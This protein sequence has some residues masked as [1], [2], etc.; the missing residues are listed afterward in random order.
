MALAARLKKM[1]QPKYQ[2][3]GKPPLSGPGFG[4]T[5]HPAVLLWPL[6]KKTPIRIFITSMGDLFHDE[7]PADFIAQCFA[8]MAL[9]GRHTFQ[10]LS[11]RHGR[12]RSLLRRG[13]FRDAVARHATAIITS[14][15]WQ[16]WQL[17][18]GGQRL[19]G[20][21]GSGGGWT[22]IKT[23]RGNVWHP[24]WPLPNVHMGVSAEDQHWFDIR[25]PA[26]RETPAAVRW[27]SAE[28]LLGPIDFGE[29]TYLDWVV[30][31]GESGPGHRPM[32]IGWLADV[33][34]QCR[35][36]G[37]PYFVKQDSGPKPGCQG[38]IPDELFVQQFPMTPA[39][40]PP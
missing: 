12:M 32:E 36:A 23:A 3:D 27:V 5:T 6:S 29:M 4:V 38:R 16:R 2:N 34:A 18:L 7:V 11:K 14:R 24:P 40:I 25:W 33:V 17:D 20:D 9:A 21:S 28:P 35:D 1:G 8:V 30:V 39:R 26:L 19:A 37:V 22:V 31:G 10:P 15:M 13:E